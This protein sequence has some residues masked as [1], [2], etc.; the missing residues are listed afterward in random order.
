MQVFANLIKFVRAAFRQLTITFL[1]LQL[2]YPVLGVQDLSER[3]KEQY[4]GENEYRHPC[5][6][7][8]P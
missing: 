5:D 7:I 6:F 1:H 3:L 4:E 8:D 2:Y